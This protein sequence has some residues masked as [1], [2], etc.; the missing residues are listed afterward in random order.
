MLDIPTFSN[1]LGKFNEEHYRLLGVA[2]LSLS[3]IFNNH[4]YIILYFT[5]SVIA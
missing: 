5:K 1:S 4:D 2:I 3:D